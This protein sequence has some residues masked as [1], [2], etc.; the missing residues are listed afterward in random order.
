MIQDRFVVIKDFYKIGSVVYACTE[1]EHLDFVEMANRL[2]LLAKSP[3]QVVILGGKT[4]LD[5]YG[6]YK[7]YIFEKDKQKL[8][9]MVSS[10]NI[11]GK[12]NEFAMA[13]RDKD[14]LLEGYNGGKL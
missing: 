8:V 13:N 6:E 1:E 5:V 4:A 9:D 10:G 2:R 12:V 7:P 3:I 14:K 11:P